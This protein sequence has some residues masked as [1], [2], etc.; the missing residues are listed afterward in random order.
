MTGLDFS[1]LK[2]RCSSIHKIMAYP[3]KNKMPVGAE[4]YIEELVDRA[5]YDF[6]TEID[7][8]QTMK[9]T[10][11][12]P[13]AIELYNELFF[14]SYE[15]CDCPKE[16]HYIKTE[17]CDIDD[18]KLD[19]VLDVKVPWSKKTFPKTQKRAHKDAK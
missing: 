18:K 19:K 2:I 11:L 6:S 7:V 9:G 5:V 4:T 8:K 1:K 14:T 10:H 12:E 13:E 16:N 17:S 15:K 3:E